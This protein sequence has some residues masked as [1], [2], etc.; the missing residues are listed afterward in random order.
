MLQGLDVCPRVHS[1]N[2]D[3]QEL[4]RY[5]NPHET[6]GKISATTKAW[7][8]VL[9]LISK[10]GPMLHSFQGIPKCL[11]LLD[12]KCPLLGSLPHL[13]LT[14]LDETL[15]RHLRSI[16][17]ITTDEEYEEYVQ[18]TERFRKGIGRRLQRYLYIKSF[19]SIN[20]VTDWWEEF[21]YLRGRSPIM[22]N[23]NYYG[24]DTLNENPTTKQAARAANC[25]WGALLFRRLIER[26]EVSP[27]CGCRYSVHISPTMI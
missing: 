13:P 11:N 18:A 16:R 1:Y 6:G 24:F 12:R 20:Y 9:K 19:L 3:N 4:L 14:G 22:I 7:F 26:Q 5:E 25:T 27:V 23:S 21:V 17:P 8:F 10:S 2:R 15:E